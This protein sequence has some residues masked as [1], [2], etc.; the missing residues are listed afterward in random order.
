MTPSESVWM[1]VGRGWCEASCRAFSM[2]ISSVCRV[3]DS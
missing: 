3:E 1:S 2:T